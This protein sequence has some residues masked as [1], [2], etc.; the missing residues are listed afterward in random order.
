MGVCSK[1]GNLLI[2]TE[3]M[4]RGSVLELLNANKHKPSPD[5]VILP[6][7]KRKIGIAKGVAQGM[8]WLVR[9]T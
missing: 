6:Q 5:D 4:A 3:L 1:P 8:N 7:L 2:V 9:V